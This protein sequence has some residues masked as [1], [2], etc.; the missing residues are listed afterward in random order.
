VVKTNG[1]KV[2]HTKDLL[3]QELSKAGLDDMAKK[4]ADGY[5]HDYLSPLATPELQLDF[6]LLDAS[7]AGNK[8]ATEL[9]ARHRA[10]E[11][12]ANKEESD[13]WAASL[14]GQEAFRKL[15]NKE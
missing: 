7:I 12:D 2:M 6:D 10:G 9:R 14:E 1:E 15:I 13:E 3:A 11:F 8:Q 5:Y 4:A